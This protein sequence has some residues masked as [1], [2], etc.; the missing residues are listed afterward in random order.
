VE[1][2]ETGRNTWAVKSDS[3]NTYTVR[4][5]TKLDEMGSMYFR[6]ECDCPSRKYPCKHA[7]AVEAQTEAVDEEAAERVQ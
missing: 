2:T 5:R 6:W 1:I 3:G 4:L 7:L